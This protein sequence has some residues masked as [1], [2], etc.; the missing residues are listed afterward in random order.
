MSTVDVET[1]RNIVRG[2]RQFTEGIIDLRL[3]GRMVRDTP[4]ERE[5]LLAILREEGF[6]DPEPVFRKGL[7]HFVIIR[8]LSLRA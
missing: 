3:F 6:S 1:E 8:P 2:L 7:V 5:E 4:E